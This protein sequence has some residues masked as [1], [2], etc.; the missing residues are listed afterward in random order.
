ML[1]NYAVTIATIRRV[2][3]DGESKE[4]VGII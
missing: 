2:I 1:V 4:S 3:K